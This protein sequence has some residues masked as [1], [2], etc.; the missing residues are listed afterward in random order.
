M[1]LAHRDKLKRW[2]RS[3]EGTEC[4]RCGGAGKIL[5]LGE[6]LACPQSFSE[7]GRPFCQEGRLHFSAYDLLN[8]DKLK[9][10]YR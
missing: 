9:K 5:Y 10:V 3:L 4:P 7:H 6:E 8:W 2:D 1:K